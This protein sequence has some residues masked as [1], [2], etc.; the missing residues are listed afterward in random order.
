MN[1]LVV[2]VVLVRGEISAAERRVLSRYELDRGVEFASPT[3][4]A[5]RPPS[6]YPSYDP[7]LVERIEAGL[8]EART[9]GSSLDEEGALGLLDRVER[10]LLSHPELPQAAFLLAEHHR[11]AASVRARSP[12][13]SAAAE[14]LERAATVLEGTRAASFGEPARN[15]TADEARVRVRVRG[16]D[17]RDRLEL[18]GVA[19][20]HE[21]E[22]AEGRHH[23]RVLR[24]DALAYAAFVELSGDSR[25]VVPGVPPLLP[26]SVDDLRGVSGER[27]FAPVAPSGIACRRW[28]VVRRSPR[29]LELAECT[30]DRCRSFSPLRAAPVSQRT[31]APA[32]A[33]PTWATIAL[34][35]LGA[36]GTS[37]LI[38]WGAGV[39][40]R[41]EPA[42]VTR[43]VYEGP[44]RPE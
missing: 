6:S 35:G 26:C 10:E 13:G 27:G 23:V 34:A 29:G 4:G 19:G 43:F 2:L 11:V 14:A 28:A 38:L 41:P 16:L 31:A 42:P 5:T 37:S 21:R 9:L 8:D 30:F 1:E 24:G 12:D 32:S 44:P 33:F 40:D 39:F 25:D 36:V 22:L 7:A 20:P 3:R 17:A 18:D 15:A